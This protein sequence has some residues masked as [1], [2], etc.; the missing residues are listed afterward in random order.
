MGGAL[1]PLDVR[2]LGLSGQR[3]CPE[4]FSLPYPAA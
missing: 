3:T 1:A 4:T 2:N